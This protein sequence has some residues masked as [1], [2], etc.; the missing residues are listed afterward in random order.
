MN[1]CFS[2]LGLVGGPELLVVVAISFLV[3]VVVS[4]LLFLVLRMV[5]EGRDTRRRLRELEK[6]FRDLRA[7]VRG[8]PPKPPR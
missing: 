7:T 2:S 3:A 1:G 6:D 8:E 5:A 4:V